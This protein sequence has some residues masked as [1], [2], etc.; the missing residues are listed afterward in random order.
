MVAE[1]ERQ[2]LDFTILEHRALQDIQSVNGGSQKMLV[3]SMGRDKAHVAR[4]VERLHRQELIAKQN[5][6]SDR[7]AVQLALTPKGEALLKR[8][9]EVEMSI[10]SEMLHGLTKEEASAFECLLNRVNENLS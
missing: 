9:D 6:P 1:V 7:R 10:V 2:G 4:I 3:E 5:N 8:L